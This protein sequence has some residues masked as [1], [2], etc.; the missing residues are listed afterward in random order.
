MLRKMI[1][2]A[3][4]ATGTAVGLTNSP[5][6]ASAQPPF[7]GLKEP[8][9]P[10]FPDRDDYLVLVRHHG[11]WDRYRVFDDWDDAQRAVWRL[12]RQGRDASIEVVRRHR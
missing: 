4:V 12:E 9:G 3:V 10:G 6:T 8:H 7:P 11:H 2:T 1:L 5:A